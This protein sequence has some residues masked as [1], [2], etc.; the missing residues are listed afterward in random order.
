MLKEEFLN[1]K[2]GDKIWNYRSNVCFEIN[3]IV[4]DA[5]LVRKIKNLKYE[6]MD[7]YINENTCDGYGIVPV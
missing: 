2:Y 6:R 3:E 1:L 4:Q 7:D 5:P